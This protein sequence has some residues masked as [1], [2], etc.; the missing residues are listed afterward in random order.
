MVRNEQEKHEAEKE[1][2]KIA[3]E[4]LRKIKPALKFLPQDFK[5]CKPQETEEP[6]PWTF[7]TTKPIREIKPR[8]QQKTHESSSD[9]EV[10]LF[11]DSD[12][13]TAGDVD[14]KYMLC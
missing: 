5:K 2:Y 7:P 3:L 14:V 9:A 12:D 6:Q 8:K 13:C 11:D 10:I 1:K 4:K